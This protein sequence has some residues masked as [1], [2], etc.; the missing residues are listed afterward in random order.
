MGD[1]RAFSINNSSSK[2]QFAFSKSDRFH[3]PR[4]YT[5]AFGYEIN[6]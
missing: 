6:G 4:A 5:N 3:T 2:A 1:R